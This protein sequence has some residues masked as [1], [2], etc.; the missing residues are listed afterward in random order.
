MKFFMK[1]I[2]ALCHP[3]LMATYVS[4]VLLSRAPELFTIQA[5]A[6]GYFVLTIFLTTCFIPAFSLFSLKLFAKVSSL[7]LTSKEERPLPFFFIT[8]W[9]AVATYLFINKLNIGAPISTIMIS[10]TI[11]IG[12]LFIIT[13]WFKISIHAAAIWGAVGI[14][15][16]L[17]ISKGII[18]T[19]V[20]YASIFLAGLTCTSRLYLG[21]H[22][23]REIWAGT[24]LGFSFSFLT[25]Y[26]FG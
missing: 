18:L 11:L 23:P 21:Y 4:T 1:L 17:M 5:Q 24:V 7:E 9:Y 12:L 10:I 26:V 8:V 14:L 13:K 15:A 16:A 25:L 20:L 2:S 3:L 22:R 6:V 19:E